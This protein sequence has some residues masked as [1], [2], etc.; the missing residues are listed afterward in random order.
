MYL[1]TDENRYHEERFEAL[2]YFAQQRHPVALHIRQ[3][4]LQPM[5]GSY[6]LALSFR[7]LLNQTSKRNLL[8]LGSLWCIRCT[9]ALSMVH[10]WS[11]VVIA[12]TF[13]LCFMLYR[14]R[15]SNTVSPD[16]KDSYTES[17]S[18]VPYLTT[19]VSSTK[20]TRISSSTSDYVRYILDQW[21]S[22]VLGLI[23]VAL[24]KIL[25]SYV[26]YRG[27][28]APLSTL[29]SV[30]IMDGICKKSSPAWHIP[31]HNVAWVMGIVA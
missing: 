10:F 31:W 25:S 29:L 26:R 23:V 24:T 16:Q 7:R 13:L 18:N 9:H 19:R 12:P 27:S 30:Q 3:M 8:R 5:I 6:M 4:I 2:D 17:F 28:L 22:C 15:R 20:D 11:L 14:T 1:N 21:F